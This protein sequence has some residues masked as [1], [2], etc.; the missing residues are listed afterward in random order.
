MLSCSGLAVDSAIQ[1]RQGDDVFQEHCTRR[2]QLPHGPEAADEALI[3]LAHLHSLRKFVEAW[4]QSSVNRSTTRSPL[5]VSN[6]TA[7]QSRTLQNDR[8]HA[9]G[10]RRA[11]RAAGCCKSRAVLGC[12]L[13]SQLLKLANCRWGAASAKLS[14]Q[15]PKASQTDV[16]LLARAAQRMD[17][18][19][20][21]GLLRALGAER[22]YAESGMQRTGTVE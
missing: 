6:S 21:A 18:S 10:Q 5:L 14:G 15:T 3:G 19:R 2:R 1:A 4:G 20:D 7:M 12:V 11:V 13:L 16:T 17:P 9:G 8:A 22:S